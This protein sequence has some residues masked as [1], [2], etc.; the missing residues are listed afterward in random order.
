MRND[1]ESYM[2]FSPIGLTRAA[3]QA[4]SSWQ[5]SFLLGAGEYAVKGVIFSSRSQLL[6]QRTPHSV[7]ARRNHV[8]KCVILGQAGGNGR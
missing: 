8:I 7:S 3:D 4:G 2:H 5:S 1:F 6:T